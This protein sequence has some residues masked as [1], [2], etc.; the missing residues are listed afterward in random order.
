[1][2]EVVGTH[3]YS[4]GMGRPALPECWQLSVSLPEC[5]E[6]SAGTPEVLGV[7]DSPSFNVGS[8][9]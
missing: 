7:V 6:C 8:G 1:M 5:R 4:V 2:S 3:S 9:Q